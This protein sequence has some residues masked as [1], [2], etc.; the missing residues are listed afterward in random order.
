[1][2]RWE[3]IGKPEE[4]PEN[5]RRKLTVHGYEIVLFHLPSGFYAVTSTCPHAGGPLEEAKVVGEHEIQCPW[6]RYRYD[7]ADGHSTNQP[8]YKARVYPVK[9]ENGE[10]YVGL[11]G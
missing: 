11:P 6:H 9:E 2:E 5:D 3:S 7:L 1:M 4:Y 8:M 10:L